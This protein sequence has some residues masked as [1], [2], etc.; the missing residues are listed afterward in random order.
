MQTKAQRPADI[1][2]GATKFDT[3]ES[4]DR[5]FRVYGDAAVMT[6]LTTVKGQYG[7]QEASGQFPTWSRCSRPSTRTPGGWGRTPWYSGVQEGNSLG[8]VLRPGGG[9]RLRPSQG[10]V[11]GVVCRRSEETNGP[12]GRS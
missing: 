6:T 7:G 4:T 10:A 3:L 5:T 11:S 8:I 2:S 9:K 12:T 1:Q